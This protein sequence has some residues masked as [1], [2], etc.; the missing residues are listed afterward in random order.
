METAKLLLDAGADITG[1]GRL[2]SEMW[3]A[4][5]GGNFGVVEL[6][7]ERGADDAEFGE[8]LVE[9]LRR[10]SEPPPQ[11]KYNSKLELKS[12]MA[13]IDMTFPNDDHDDNNA[14][15]DHNS[16]AKANEDI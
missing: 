16:N 3:A 15:D 6:L 12:L 11:L 5:K 14:N 4:S 1:P 8:T 2:L 13:L 7:I 9:L 10:L